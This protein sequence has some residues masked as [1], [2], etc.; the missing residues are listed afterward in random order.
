VGRGWK[1]EEGKETE[2][3]LQNGGEKRDWA[4]RKKGKTTKPLKFPCVKWFR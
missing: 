3:V 1:G 4:R 2:D